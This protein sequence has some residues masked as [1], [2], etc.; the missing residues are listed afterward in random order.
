MYFSDYTINSS[1]TNE[2]ADGDRDENLWEEDL[3]D[4]DI[5]DD[6]L[7]PEAAGEYGGQRPEYNEE[8]YRRM[9]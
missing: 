5:P 4:V 8:G 9:W 6:D 2:Y 7:I 1:D 3:L